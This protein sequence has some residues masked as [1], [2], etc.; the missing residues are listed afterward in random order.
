MD[1]TLK[2]KLINSTF[3]GI[4]KIIENTYKNHPD[5][6]SY[7]VCRLQEG[8]DDY[9]KITFKKG[10]IEYHKNDFFGVIHLTLK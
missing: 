10:K 8:Y 3:Q 6:K 9:L 4:N 7:S 5:E 1:K 2:E